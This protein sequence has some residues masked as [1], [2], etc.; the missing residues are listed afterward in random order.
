[1]SRQAK[2]PL[3]FMEENFLKASK[4]T[5]SKRK[6]L[7]LLGL[8]HVQKGMSYKDAGKSC[9]VS[10]MSIWK[11][12]VR[13]KKDG[14]TGLSDQPRSGR[15]RLLNKD[16][17]ELFKQGFLKIQK[18][19]SGGRLTGASARKLASKFGANYSNNSIYVLLHECGLS[20]IS[21]RSKHPSYDKRSQEEFKKT[22]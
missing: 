3:H 17:H 18:R 6:S 2:L 11:W 4:Q 1:M 15:P 9:G 8:H 14:I 10:Y 19:M 16:S 20:W 5:H 12:V 13:Y 7:R 22:S 21:G